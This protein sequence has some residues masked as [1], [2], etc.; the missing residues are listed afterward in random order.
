MNLNGV[1][2]WVDSV[3]R[4]PLVSRINRRASFS[5]GFSAQ[6]SNRSFLVDRKAERCGTKQLVAQFSSS[7]TN[8]VVRRQLIAV[9]ELLPGI[10]ASGRKERGD[11]LWVSTGFFVRVIDMAVAL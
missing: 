2:I 8:S 10:W 6:L 4:S 1:I 5:D 9:S 11:V 7:S 3:L